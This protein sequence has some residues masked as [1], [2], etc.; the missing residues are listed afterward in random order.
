MKNQGLLNPEIIAQVASTGHTQYICIADCGLPVPSGV[1][2][3]DVSVTKGIPSFMDVLNAVAGELVVESIVV[4]KEIEA[5]NL[6]LLQEIKHLLG[7]LPTEKIPHEEFKKRVEKAQ[8]V[9]RTGEATPY[10]NI[11]LIGGVN[12]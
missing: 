9:I 5:F 3:I 10:G 12:F 4:A 7:E 6:N 2:V 1:R 8:C 11:L